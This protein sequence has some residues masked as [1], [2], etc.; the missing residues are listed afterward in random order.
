MKA[1]TV[2]LGFAT[3]IGLM[4]APA[5]GQTLSPEMADA[6]AWLESQQ[7][8]DGS[9]G[10]GDDRTVGRATRP[11]T[12]GLQIVGA[13]GFDNALALAWLER[14][15]LDNTDERVRQGILRRDALEDTG[16]I[17]TAILNTKR[18]ASTSG[19]APNAPEGGWG[20]L[21]GYGS[22][23]IDTALA[24]RYLRTAGLPEGLGIGPR[25]LAASAIDTFSFNLP[26]GAT[27]V[28]I[29]INQADGQINFQV[30][31]GSPPGP[32]DLSYDGI[33][34]NNINLSGLNLD[35]GPNYI[36]VE[37]VVSGNYAFTV[38]FTVDGFSTL[39]IADP[40]EYLIAAQNPDGGWGIQVLRDSNLYLT[41][42]AL[43]ALLQ[44]EES[45][46]LSTVIQNGIAYVEGLQNVDGS[47]GSPSGTVGDTAL[48]YR[49]LGTD[50]LAAK[51]SVD[52]LSWLIGQQG[53]S[54]DWNADPKDTADALLALIVSEGKADADSDGISDW[55][56]NCPTTSNAD[57][58]DLDGDGMGDVCDDDIDGDG[59]NND[60]ETNQSLTDP[61]NAD[62]DGNG[63]PD[64]LEDGDLDGTSNLEEQ[65]GGSN[66]AAPSIPLHAGF[67]LFVYPLV[68]A[69]GY[70][71]YDLLSDLGGYM[72]VDS[73]SK[74]D[75]ATGLYQT[76][77]YNGVLPQGTDFDIEDGVGMIVNALRATTVPVSGKVST[78][79]PEVHPGPNIIRIPTAPAGYT[80]HD[81]FFD[82]SDQGVVASIQRY[83]P[84]ENRFLTVSVYNNDLNGPAFDVDPNEPYLVNMEAAQPLLNV[85]YPADGDLVNTPNITITGTVSS[86]VNSV[87]INGQSA[88]ITNGIFSLP[89]TL[90]TGENILY[91][92]AE[93]G[94]G[95]FN[96]YAK[97]QVSVTYDTNVD[98]IMPVGSLIADVA[99]VSGDSGVMSQVATYTESLNNVPAGVTYTTTGAAFI[100]ATEV[101]FDFEIFASG[102]AVPGTYSFTV[103]YNLLDGGGTSLGPLT[104]NILDITIQINP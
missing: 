86:N 27:N 54:G 92:L 77:E 71:A 73:V 82:L 91:I 33:S 8:A 9:W 7:N 35:A 15:P 60:F 76:A 80:A 26:Q 62:T 40:V 43:L 20:L 102:S 2:T 96:G 99:V 59:L 65:D 18:E 25:F 93:N 38:S 12:L 47:F 41:C 51:S 90:T 30:K 67:N 29:V 14:L 89:Y 83:L 22:D 1:L 97:D 53:A 6:V 69:A 101:Q 4:S 21:D 98:Y 11:A 63:V 42:E 39:T 13:S 84:M 19:T 32:G 70:S 68:P 78:T 104:G 64:G 17:T 55:L 88:T 74:Y 72:V 81:L 37:G 36:R 50:D 58:S 52:A 34:G 31:S 10:T 61:N 23:T 44:Y 94:L 5:F 46:D 45:Q 3:V 28:A 95:G 79:T 24:L 66:P 75:P 16:D 56:D 103:E 85:S 48:A 57:Q 87:V 100:S 49:V